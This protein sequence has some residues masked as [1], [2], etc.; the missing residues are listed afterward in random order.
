MNFEDYLKKE[1]KISLNNTLN[2]KEV[3][4]FFLK[5]RCM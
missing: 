2:K 3:K 4:S 5:T 1:E